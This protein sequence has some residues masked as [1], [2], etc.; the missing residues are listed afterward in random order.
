MKTM[1]LSEKICFF[2]VSLPTL[3]KS[4]KTRQPRIALH[5]A[6]AVDRV[7]SQSVSSLRF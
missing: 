7:T 6:N 2:I 1:L 3:E 5:L 4:I